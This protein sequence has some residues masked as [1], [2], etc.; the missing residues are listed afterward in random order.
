MEPE[1]WQEIERLC[2]SALNK[3]K[4]ARA[5]FLE[6]GCGGDEALRRAVELLLA[7]H[8]K[9]DDFLEV[10]AMEVPAK[11]LATGQQNDPPGLR[12]PPTPPA[13]PPPPPP[14]TQSSPSPTAP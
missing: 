5:A 10:P 1:R 11:H 9:D 2:Y 6:Q 7:Q 13:P 4:S 14:A 12:S 3:E 8:E